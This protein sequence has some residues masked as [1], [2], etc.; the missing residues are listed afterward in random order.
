MLLKKVPLSRWLALGFAAAGLAAQTA[1]LIVRSRAVDLPPLVGSTHDFLLVL[2]WLAIV[3]YLFLELADRKLALGL[4]VLPIVLVLVGVAAF[5]SKQPNEQMNQVR[6]LER[7]G[8]LHASLLVFGMAGV[9][10]SLVASLMYLVQHRRLKHKQAEPQGLH[11]LSL[12]KLNSLNWWAIV[13]SVPLLTLGMA[14]GVWLSYLSKQTAHPIPLDR[15]EFFVY[16]ALWIGMAVLFLWLLLARRP[17][18]RVVAW[19][20]L[21]ACGFLLATILFLGVF[22]SGGVHGM[23]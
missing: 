17:A 12:E 21:W 18:G 20:T 5:V 1:Y 6:A 16:G 22:S 9:A 13:V 8:M 7:L 4:F 23:G 15:P 10:T 14:S 2:A 19:R 3:L 11:L